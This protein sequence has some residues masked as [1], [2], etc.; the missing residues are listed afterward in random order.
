M[1]QKSTNFIRIG[2]NSGFWYHIKELILSLTQPNK[3]NLH[4]LIYYK[5]V[6]SIIDVRLLLES[7]KDFCSFNACM[8][9]GTCLVQMQAMKRFMEEDANSVLDPR[10]DQTAAN[11]LALHKILELALQCLA[12]RRQNRPTMKRC[13]EILWSIRK[14]F[15]EQLSA[16]NFRSFSTTS[17]RSTSLREWQG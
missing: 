14:D 13:A 4:S 9:N 6:L 2:S 17:Q 10:L 11:T 12:P 3:T 16:S 1:K 8:V 7:V 15:R 5:L